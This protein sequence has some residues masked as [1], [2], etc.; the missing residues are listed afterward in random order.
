MQI[1]EYTPQSDEF[2][3]SFA[4]LKEGNGDVIYD[5][6]NVTRIWVEDDVVHVEGD[7]DRFVI[8]MHIR[9][10]GWVAQERIPK[11]VRAEIFS[12]KQKKRAPQRTELQEI[13][14]TA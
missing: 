10:D 9:W 6:N 4:K 14:H 2:P 11:N 5:V 7:S 12:G 13:G 1:F 3:V 8:R